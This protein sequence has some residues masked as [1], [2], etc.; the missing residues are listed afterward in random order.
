MVEL[1]TPG[2]K[3]TRVLSGSTS[4]YGAI[5]PGFE[6]QRSPYSFLEQCNLMFLKYW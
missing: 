5:G 4:D 1:K 2:L 3:G 6:P